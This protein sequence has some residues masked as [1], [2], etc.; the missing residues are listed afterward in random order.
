[1]CFSH[2][3]VTNY[4][5]SHC[6]MWYTV[7]K[8]KCSPLFWYEAIIV[9]FSQF[10]MTVVQN[11]ATLSKKR[12]PGTGSS[13]KTAGSQSVKVDGC[14]SDCYTITKSYNNSVFA[15]PHFGLNIGD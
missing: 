1:M 11:Q 3:P 9:W 4:I 12:W 6:M 5:Y 8:K 14:S 7:R 2:P 10:T 15:D 13:P